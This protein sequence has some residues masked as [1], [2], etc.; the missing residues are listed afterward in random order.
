M[1]SANSSYDDE[2]GDDLTTFP[3][4]ERGGVAEGVELCGDALAGC[5]SFLD[6]YDLAGA[7]AVCHSWREAALRDDLW[8][9]LC[10]ARWRLQQEKKGRYKYGEER[11]WREVYRVFHRR[12]RPPTVGGLG[13]RE[14]AWACGRNH[15]VCCWLYVSHAPACRLPE[16]PA[17]GAVDPDGG[18][19]R[20]VLVCRIVTQNLRRGP[21]ELDAAGGVQLVLRDG[22]TSRPEPSTAAATPPVPA[23]R[24]EPQA[25]AVVEVRLPMPASMQFEPDALE[26]CHALRVRVA[27][28]PAGATGMARRYGLAFVEVGCPFANVEAAI[29]EH[30]ERVNPHFYVHHDA[31]D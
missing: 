26:A 18:A 7:A 24:L 6:A 2:E 20:R 14:V 13:E 25:V 8:G 3:Y 17:A 15:R 28:L 4:D 27:C 21:I 9:S 11:S 29:W 19:P 30:Y 10:R 23:V 22:G 5:F 31:R 12:F 16:S 1:G